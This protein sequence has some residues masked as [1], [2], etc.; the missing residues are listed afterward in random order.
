MDSEGSGTGL[1]GF[2]PWQVVGD[3]VGR[4]GRWVERLRGPDDGSLMQADWLLRSLPWGD[5]R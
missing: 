4:S 5:F 1:W 2:L 3:A